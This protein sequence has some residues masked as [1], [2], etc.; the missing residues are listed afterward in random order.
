MLGHPGRGLQAPGWPLPPPGAATGVAQ[1]QVAYLFGVHARL[2]ARREALSRGQFGVQREVGAA[3]SGRVVGA[4]RAPACGSGNRTFL[5]IR[6]GTAY[7][8]HL[9]SLGWACTDSRW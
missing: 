8:A 4:T 7:L 3:A 1:G 5:T 6:D 2:L 9:F